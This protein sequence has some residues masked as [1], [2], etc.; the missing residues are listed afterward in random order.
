M[1]IALKIFFHHR[2]SGPCARA[3]GCNSSSK[4][5]TKGRRNEGHEEDGQHGFSLLRALRPFAP[6]CLVLAS[7]LSLLVPLRVMAVGT[8]HWI[9]QSEA[10]WKAGTFDGVVATNLG[11]LKL[12]RAVKTLLSE[13]ARVSS[14][15]CFAEAADGTMYVGTGPQGVLLAVKGETVTTVLKLGD[16]ANIFSL[17]FDNQGRLLIGTGGDKGQVLRLDHPGTEG[18]KPK[19]IFSADGVQ[20]IWSMTKSPDGT[21]YAATGPNGQ[22]FQINP[23]GSNKVLFSCE[24]NNLLTL[25]TDGKDTLYAG[26][27]PSGLVYRINRKTGAA[28]ILYD[29]QESEVKS[30]ALDAQGNLY[31][32]TAEADEPAKVAAAGSDNADRVGRPEKSATATP[33][34]SKPP[35]SP[36][37]PPLPLPGPGE[38]APIPKSNGKVAASHPLSLRIMDDPDPGVPGGGDPEPAQP[39][40]QSQPD[41]SAQGPNGTLPQQAAAADNSGKSQQ[42]GNAIYKITPDG[43]VTEVFREQVTVLSLI[44]HDG[45]LMAGTGSDGVIYQIEPAAEETIVAAKVDP[46][47]VTA[48]FRGSDGRLWMGLANSGQIAT[49]GASF[50]TTGTYTSEAL[51]AKQVSRFGKINLRGSLP[52]G[53]TLTVATRSGNIDDPARKGW[54]G[55]SDEIPATEY[56][57]VPSPSARFLQYRLTFSSS[58]GKDTPIVDSV[59]TAYQMPNM[60]P[61]IHSVKVTP[62]G[63]AAVTPVDL[64]SSAIPAPSPVKTI[65][66]E[67][68]DPNNDTLQYTLYFRTGSSG[69]WILLKDKLT[70]VTFDWNT[71]NVA[72]G[73][74]HLKVVASDA[75]ANP[76]GQ[77]KSA[78]RVSEEIVVDNTPPEIGDL[79]V[80]AGHG[81]A[82][83]E[84]K[85]VDQTSTV[86]GLA[87]AIDSADDWQAVL[88]VDTIADSPE[89]AYSFVVGG[90]SAGTHQVT[91]R[92]TD[93]QGN[94]SYTTVTVT[95]EAPATSKE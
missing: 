18:G 69:E 2:S 85:V 92:A 32:G 25:I 41:A 91:L 57:A 55:W 82:K 10:D 36:K 51:D 28:F 42:N 44:E 21:L 11:D 14:V 48:L 95:A 47:D 78:S 68:S 77:G 1:K 63:K 56:V 88:P 30:L 23:D 5:N 16:N 76:I 89:E 49:L 93:S 90:L 70:D 80:T 94:Q 67:A 34:P 75:A 17:L 39:P 50:A 60:A 72:D 46:K 73:H 37:P 66:W 40:D 12:S 52:K 7:V 61:E 59:N 87:F 65:T 84:T 33:I 74:Y 9:Q 53:T 81:E 20:Y 22:L 62:Q 45:T 8:S 24:E 58:D 19:E 83:I 27:D 35:T 71:R 15:Y 79:K 26:S 13:D 4:L 54:S 64:D 29:A 6:S 31:A 86:A 3:E 38:P 43:F